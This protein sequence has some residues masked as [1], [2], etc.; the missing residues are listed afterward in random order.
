MDTL[1]TNQTP[2]QFL[3]DAG[4]KSFKIIQTI[5]GKRKLVGYYE[6]WDKLQQ[7]IYTPQPWKDGVLDWV[8]HSAPTKDVT[9]SKKKHRSQKNKDCRSSGNPATGTNTIPLTKGRRPR[10]NDNKE[11]PMRSSDKKNQPRN[12]PKNSQRPNQQKILAEIRGLFE[13]LGIME[14]KA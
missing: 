14:G 6:S 13:K 8:C 11:T 7:R 1:L 2:S 3:Q 12:H 9:A 10:K 4:F 5:D